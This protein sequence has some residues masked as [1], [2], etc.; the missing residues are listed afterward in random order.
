MG[1]GI[2][3]FNCIGLVVIL[4]ALSRIPGTVYFPTLGCAVV[5]LDNLFAHFHWKE[6]LTRPAV[7]GAVLAVFSLSLVI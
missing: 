5:I 3:L 7:A 4:I 2:G 6:R 1:G